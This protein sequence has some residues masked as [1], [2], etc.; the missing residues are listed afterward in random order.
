MWAMLEVLITWNGG[1]T[2]LMKLQ[3][4]RFAI[5]LKCR[6]NQTK[7]LTIPFLYKLNGELI[8]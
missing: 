6:F 2:I 3:N 1:S 4:I 5:F 7:Y 8:Y